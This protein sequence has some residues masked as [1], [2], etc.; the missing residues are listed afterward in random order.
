MRKYLF[1]LLILASPF[2]CL[3]CYAQKKAKIIKVTVEPKE[4][5]IYIN[6]TFAGYGYAEFT[7]PKKKN[8]VMIIRCE[9]DEYKEVLTKF[10]GGDKRSSISISLQQDGFFRSSAAS[11]IV[12]KFFTIMLDSQYYTINDDKVDVAPAWKL[13]HQILLNYFDEIETTDVHGGYLQTPWQYKSFIMS[14]KQIRNRV[15]IR[16]ISTPQR[17]AFQ[18]KIS[19]E[20]AGSMAARHGEFTE[21]DRI[22][23][24]FEPLIE[25]LQTRIGKVSS[26]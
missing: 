13:L 14:E 22:P 6:N 12:N 7:R 15:T 1:L 4:A 9:C 20:V 16:D 18:I 11:G 25:E 21:I 24:D 3:E 10:Y 2:I 17:V 5:S 26:L 8:E 19:S 23:K